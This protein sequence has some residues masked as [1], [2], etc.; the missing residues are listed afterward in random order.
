[1]FVAYYHFMYMYVY[2]H[3]NHNCITVLG[4]RAGE[5]RRIYHECDSRIEKSVPRITVWHQEACR[6]IA[7]GDQEGQIFQSHP[8]TNN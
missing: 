6:V 3:I 5:N 7:N 4:E 2:V 8:N 1:M